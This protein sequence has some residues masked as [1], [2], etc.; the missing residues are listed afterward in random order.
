MILSKNKFILLGILLGILAWLMETFIDIFVFNTNENFFIALFFPNSHEFWMRS[1]S[2]MLFVFLGCYSQIISERK[3]KESNKKFQKSEENYNSF[4][5]NFDGIVFQRY[6]NLSIGFFSGAVEEITGYSEGEFALDQLKWNQIIHPKDKLR[7]DKNVMKFHLSSVKSD[8]WEYRIIHKDGSILWVLEMSQKIYDDSRK[9]LGVQGTIHNI[10]K[11]KHAKQK[12][13]ESESMLQKAEEIARIGTWKLNG[14]NGKVN[15][16]KGMYRIFDFEPDKFDGSFKFAMNKIHP[17]DYFNAIVVPELAIKEKESY[18]VEYRFIHSDGKIINLLAIGNVICN[19]DGELIELIGTVQDITD[20]KKAGEKLKESEE[21]FRTIAEQSFMGIGI[22]QNN[23]VK[24]A[25]EALAK[26]LEYPLEEILTTKDFNVDNIIHHEDLLA[27]NQQRRLIREGKLRLKPYNSYRIITKSHKTKWVDQYSKDIL[28]RGKKAELLTIVDITERKEVEKLIIQ[29]NEKLME[30]N[31]L[32]KDMI[33]RVSH[34]LK[35]PLNA[36]YGTSQMLLNYYSKD[37]GE[38]IF[39]HIES[40][41]KGGE[42]LS[43]LIDDLIDCSRVESKKLGL[44]LRNENLVEIIKESVEELIYLANKRGIFLNL[45]MQ[46]ELYAIVDKIRIGQVITNILSNAIKNTPV[47]G[48][49]YIKT[50]EHLDYLDIIIQDTGVGLTQ[51]EIP[52]LFTKFG[53]IERHGKSLG[54]DIEGSGLGLYIS[55]EIINL[56]GGQILVESEGRNKGST[57]IIK[58]LKKNSDLKNKKD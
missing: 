8:R 53:K 35:T 10:T 5:E 33:T 31:Q 32:R 56:H 12:L 23:Q 29:E 42:R 25:N 55:K 20:R 47:N 44:N 34:E 18:Q 7:H 39:K 13:K 28:Y 46:K 16:S 36:I 43:K 2:L 58:L 57:F 52:L 24:Y 40:I 3:I 4:L 19:E 38:K 37:I 50:F 48:N 14:S 11:Q 54:V 41:N 26:I 21:K 15:W 1:L 49:I 9:E 45:D 51:K 30:L 22:I 17:D 27:I 6:E